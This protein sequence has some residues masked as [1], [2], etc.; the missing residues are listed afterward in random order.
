MKDP[1]TLPSL[2]TLDKDIQLLREKVIPKP[3]PAQRNTGFAMQLGLEL[4]SGVLVGAFIGIELD[5]WLGTSPLFLFICF[6]LGTAGGAMTLYRTATAV[7]E[8]ADKADKD[9][10]NE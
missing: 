2:E 9:D 3:R 7:N 4:V 1:E 10:I 5:K 8:G 6:F